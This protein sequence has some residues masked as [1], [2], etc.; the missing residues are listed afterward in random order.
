MSKPERAASQM[1]HS[2]K[3]VAGAFVVL[4]LLIGCSGKDSK[5]TSVAQDL[6]ANSSADV[7]QETIRDQSGKSITLPKA[8]PGRGSSPEQKLHGHWIMFS[9]AAINA[10]GQNEIDGPWPMEEAW[11]VYIDTKSGKIKMLE[12][13]DSESIDESRF[14][15]IS[16]NAETGDIKIEWWDAKYDELPVSERGAAMR[17]YT[18]KDDGTCSFKEGVFG[19]IVT[20]TLRRIGEE[21]SP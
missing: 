1:R 17:E 14:S 3:C 15:V 13:T 18:V 21:T 9:F 7:Q 8:V 11:H 6:A 4:P 10:S 20:F 2:G 5:S 12:I 19:T 16:Q